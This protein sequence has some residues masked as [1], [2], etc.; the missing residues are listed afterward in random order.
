LGGVNFFS[1]SLRG[2]K[3]GISKREKRGD[4]EEKSRGRKSWGHGEKG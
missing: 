4:H 1:F 3:N 2:G